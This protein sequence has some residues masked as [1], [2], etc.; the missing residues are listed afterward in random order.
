MKIKN[1]TDFLFNDAVYDEYDTDIV[2]FNADCSIELNLHDMDDGFKKT[3]VSYVF[4]EDFLSLNVGKNGGVSVMH[5]CITVSISSS[6][7]DIV[8]MIGNEIDCFGEDNKEY[9]DEV[10]PKFKQKLIEAIGVIDNYLLSKNE[11][12]GSPQF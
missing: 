7:F 3:I 11:K 8:E 5:D 4:D 2:R 10:L 1:D 6:E 12:K 9:L